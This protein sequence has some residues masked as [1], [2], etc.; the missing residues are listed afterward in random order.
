[1]SRGLAAGFITSTSSHAMIKDA[2][3]GNFQLLYFT[4]EALLEN[5]RWRRLLQDVTYATRIKCCVIDEA[6][7][8]KKWYGLIGC[9]CMI[10]NVIVHF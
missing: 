7:T 9:T 2:I 5:K 3:A 6:H 1:M 4:P 8:V 10:Y